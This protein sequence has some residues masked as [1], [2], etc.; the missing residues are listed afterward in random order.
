MYHTYNTTYPF[1]RKCAHLPTQITQFSPQ[2]EILFKFQ[3]HSQR[4][5]HHH[6]NYSFVSFQNKWIIVQNIDMNR[7]IFRFNL[8][9]ILAVGIVMVPTLTDASCFEAWSRC[10]GWSSGGTRNVWKT[11]AGRCQLDVRQVRAFQPMVVL[12]SNVNV[13]G[14]MFHEA[15]TLWTGSPASSD[16]RII[17]VKN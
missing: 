13:R 17:M 8:I 10:T 12:I 6:S 16:C 7:A 9:I 15:Q 4:A 11:C 1:S 2:H 5:A 14:E 3:A